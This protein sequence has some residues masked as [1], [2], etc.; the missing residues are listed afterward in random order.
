MV[1]LHSQIHV[2][3]IHVIGVTQKNIHHKRGGGG[4]EQ[5]RVVNKNRPPPKEA[6]RQKKQ[7]GGDRDHRHQYLRSHVLIRSGG[8]SY[9]NATDLLFTLPFFD[10]ALP[11]YLHVI[12]LAH[13]DCL[14][15]D[16][17]RSACN[18]LLIKKLFV[19][20]KDDGGQQS[21]VLVDAP[22]RDTPKILNVQTRF[23]AVSSLLPVKR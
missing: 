16:D 22:S 6:S 15:D 10:L 7:R 19:V 1:T 18:V 5:Q 2:N 14:D 3:A 17:R 8:R 20:N 13:A 12:E 11:C 21:K 23:K 4:G 9:P